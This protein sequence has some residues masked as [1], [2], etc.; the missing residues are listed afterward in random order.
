M[1]YIVIQLTLV[2]LGLVI[3]L[4]VLVAYICCKVMQRG[5]VFRAIERAREEAMHEDVGDAGARSRNVQGR[6]VSA[7]P[8]DIRLKEN[9]AYGT[10]F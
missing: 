7:K 4:V 5:D 2:V 1:A 3:A 6:N 9:T 10:A 8:Q